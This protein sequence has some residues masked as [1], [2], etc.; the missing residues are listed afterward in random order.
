MDIT[1]P[2]Y[3]ELYNL[4]IYPD[5][6][7]VDGQEK[8]DILK[9]YYSYLK[10]KKQEFKSENNIHAVMVVNYYKTLAFN[11]LVT[12]SKNFYKKSMKK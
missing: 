6:N 2:K 5:F 12:C 1:N 3:L 9:N 7:T 10:D 11:E 4:K 8:V